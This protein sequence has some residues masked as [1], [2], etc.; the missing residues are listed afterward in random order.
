MLTRQR[1][2]GSAARVPANRAAMLRAGVVGAVTSRLRRF[3]AN[4]RLNRDGPGPHVLR[5][6]SGVQL[7]FELLWR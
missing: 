5:M 3:S 2:L 4:R 1:L 7:L 6:A